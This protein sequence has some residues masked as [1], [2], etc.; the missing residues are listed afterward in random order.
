MSVELF[1]DNSFLFQCLLEV[2]EVWFGFKTTLMESMTAKSTAH[3]EVT[4]K[5]LK[6][7]SRIPGTPSEAP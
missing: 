5:S 6:L 2:V 1:R 4:T 7:K 3:G